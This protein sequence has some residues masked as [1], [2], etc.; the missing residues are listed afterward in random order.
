MAALPA[1]AR[2]GRRP[3]YWT[4]E[5]AG[6]PGRCSVGLQ[7]GL[8]MTISRSNITTTPARH[9][10]TSGPIIMG[11]SRAAAESPP[12]LLVV[13]WRWTLRAAMPV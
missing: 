12:G 6:T 2:Q 5:W 8:P 3:T 1:G 4:V 7:S 10:K 9:R 11:A 13:P